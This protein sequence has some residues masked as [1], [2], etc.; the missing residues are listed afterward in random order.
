[1][2]EARVTTLYTENEKDFRKIPWI[3]VKNPLWLS[4]DHLMNYN[5]DRFFDSIINEKITYW[6][7]FDT[8]PFIVN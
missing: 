6:K 8:D 3:E 4:T 5:L 2:R 7:S 1:M